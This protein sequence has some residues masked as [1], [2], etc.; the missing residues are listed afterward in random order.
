MHEYLPIP[1]AGSFFAAASGSLGWGLGAAIGAAL[2]A[3]DRRVLALLGDGSSMYAIQGLW[4]AAQLGVPVTFVIMDNRSYAAMDEFGRYLGFENA[5]SFAL[6]GLDFVRAA[7][8][9]GVR[10]VR[11]EHADELEPALRAAFAADTP[12]LISVAVEAPANRI[13]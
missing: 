3:P 10:G 6:P 4:T 9:F 2:A 7:E 13:Y 1:D 11:I 5:P 8:A 12:V